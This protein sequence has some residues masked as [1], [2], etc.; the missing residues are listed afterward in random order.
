MPRRKTDQKRQAPATRTAKRKKARTQEEVGEPTQDTQQQNEAQQSIT[1]TQQNDQLTTVLDLDTSGLQQAVTESV[2]SAISEHVRQ[3]V[4]A[5]LAK[6]LPQ[7]RQELSTVIGSHTMTP[8]TAPSTWTPQNPTGG[9]GSTDQGTHEQPSEMSTSRGVTV[10]GQGPTPVVSRGAGVEGLFSGNL[11]ELEGVGQP[12]IPFSAPLSLDYAIN[13][14]TRNKIW[15]N[16]YVEFGNLLDTSNTSQNKILLQKTD[17]GDNTLCVVPTNKKLPKNINDWI[18]AF[19]IFSTI[20][21]KKFPNENGKLLKYGEVVRQIAAE[22]GNF[23]LYDV[24]FR[25]L[26]Q[27]TDLPWNHFHTE[28]FLK[29]TQSKVTNKASVQ[30]TGEPEKFPVG[31]CFRFCR[32]LPCRGFCGFKHKC[33]K[34]MGNHPV[35]RCRVQFQTSN[36]NR[37]NFRGSF[38]SRYQQIASQDNPPREQ[39]NQGAGRGRGCPYQRR[40]FNTSK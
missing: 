27:V 8:A 38:Q 23:N 4:R 22:G 18:S 19:S 36:R 7:Q 31:Y 6:V 35:S 12:R 14:E 15:I 26:R 30:T 16:E 2:V 20:Y 24:N 11:G 5:E 39:P 40:T 10:V 34:C 17:T 21:T 25:K 1:P 9:T 13:P 3:A 37:G 33:T 28:L 32:G 29:A